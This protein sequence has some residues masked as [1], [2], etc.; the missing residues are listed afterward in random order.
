M[1]RDA[2]E[3]PGE[4][5]DGERIGTETFVVDLLDDFRHGGE[6]RR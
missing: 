1:L 5:V 2:C 4:H 3:R 6:K